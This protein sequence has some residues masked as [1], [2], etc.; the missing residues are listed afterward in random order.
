MNVLGHRAKQSRG[1]SPKLNHPSN[2]LD[3]A[4][5]GAE[6]HPG[7][8]AFPLATLHCRSVIYTMR[9]THISPMLPFLLK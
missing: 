3:T 2:L 9:G 1:N 8:V 6:T 5:K 7:T 4:P